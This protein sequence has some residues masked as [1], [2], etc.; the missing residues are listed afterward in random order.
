MPKNMDNLL[1]KI[2]ALPEERRR[3][4]LWSIVGV[5]ALILFSLWYRNFKANLDNLNPQTIN[6]EVVFMEQEIFQEVD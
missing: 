4:I 1:K 6:P 2:Q 5:L 3:V